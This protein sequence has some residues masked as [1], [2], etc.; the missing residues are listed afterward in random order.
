MKGRPVKMNSNS[1]TGVAAPCGMY[2][3]NCREAPDTEAGSLPVCCEEQFC[4]A[5]LGHVRCEIYH[6]V[7]GRGLVDCAACAEFPCATLLRFAHDP[8]NN[9]RLPLI[10][11]LQLRRQLGREDWL[12]QEHR[13][14]G[15]TDSACDWAKLRRTLTQK[16]CRFT[17]IQA[18]V[19]EI[20]R[21]VESLRCSPEF[22]A[23]AVGPA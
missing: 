1:E 14:W 6:C 13:F 7:A 15:R 17:E 11:N 19:C 4:P 5:R 21:E 2:S 9:E 16:W 18:Q 3:D 22:D 23:Q 20:T 12:A 10:V 8:C